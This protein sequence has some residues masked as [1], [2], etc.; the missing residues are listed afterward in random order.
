MTFVRN[1]DG[2]QVFYVDSSTVD[3][4]STCDI[5]SV[6]LYFKSKPDLLLNLNDYTTGAYVC[7]VPT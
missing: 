3:G 6:N 7:V 2:A 5:S 4:A 1:F